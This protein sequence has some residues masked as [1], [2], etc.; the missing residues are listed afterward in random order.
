MDTGDH[1][2]PLGLVQIHREG[3][4][5]SDPTATQYVPFHA[6][7]F[8]PEIEGGETADTQ[9]CPSALRTTPE[10]TATHVDPFH[11]TSFAVDKTAPDV[12]DHVPEFALHSI[13]SEPE[14]TAT[15]MLSV[16]SSPA[17]ADVPAAFTATTFPLASTPIGVPPR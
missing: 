16:K 12:V 4:T 5:G 8:R 7:P 11:A 2:C 6:M 15:T 17:S 3:N 1:D 14:P 10:P 13:E 9:F